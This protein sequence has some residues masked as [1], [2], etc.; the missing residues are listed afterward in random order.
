[1]LLRLPCDARQHQVPAWP[2]VVPRTIAETSG[3]PATEVVAQLHAAH[4][5]GQTRAG[6]DI[7]TGQ[8]KDLTEDSISDTLSTRWCGPFQAKGFN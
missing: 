4:A 6:L 7:L 5:E 1:M 2:Q 3:L 8:P